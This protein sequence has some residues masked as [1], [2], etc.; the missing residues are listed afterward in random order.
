[1]IQIFCDVHCVVRWMLPNIFEEFSAFTF[2][3]RQ[4]KTR[5]YNHS[6]TAS[7]PKRPT[8]LPALLQ[9]PQTL[10]QPQA[11]LFCACKRTFTNEQ[12]I[13]I[14][15]W[16]G[17]IPTDKH[18]LISISLLSNPS[19]LYKGFKVHI[20]NF[21]LNNVT[22]YIYK[23]LHAY[24]LRLRD[25]M[26]QVMYFIHTNIMCDISEWFCGPTLVKIHQGLYWAHWK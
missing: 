22:T 10:H 17:Q 13:C 3:V 25:K 1:M 9:E 21:F 5:H 6:N 12:Y 26:W 18:T 14:N 7:Y 4:P 19:S 24:H 15:S 11:T 16:L 20:Y 23:F 2:R 8:S